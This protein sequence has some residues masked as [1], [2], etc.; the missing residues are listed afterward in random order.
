M[1]KTHQRVSFSWP[2]MAA[3]VL[4]SSLLGAACDSPSTMFT[5]RWET[6]EIE[7]SDGLF[8]GSPV[9]A[10]GQYGAEV[11]GVL[12]HLKSPGSTTFNEDCPCAWLQHHRVNEAEKEVQFT[13]ICQPPEATFTGPRLHWRLRLEDDERDEEE[14]VVDGLLVGTVRIDGAPED[15]GIPVSFVRIYDYLASADKRCPPEQEDETGNAP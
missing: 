14:I 13:T 11:A 1:S 12:Y 9:V 7:A 3:L 6:L 5:G 2:F 10:L 15:E 8:E 4:L